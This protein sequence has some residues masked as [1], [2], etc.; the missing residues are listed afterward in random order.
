M[1]AKFI[2]FDMIIREDGTILS[3]VTHREEG[4][5]CQAMTRLVQQMGTVVSDEITG[6]LCDKQHERQV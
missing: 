4:A 5:E 6:P 3:E 2:E 1:S